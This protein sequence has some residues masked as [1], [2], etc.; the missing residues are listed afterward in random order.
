MS[1]SIEKLINDWRA[2]VEQYAKAKAAAEY[3]KEYRKS[4][5]AMLIAEAEQ[6]GLKT[7][8]ERESYAYAHAEYVELLQG[9]REAIEQSESLRWRM[10][11]AQDRVKVWQTKCANN[12]KEQGMYGA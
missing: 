11:I 1:E 8:Q 4:K 3:L 5:K 7:G 6:N 2:C 10:N 9:L 12:R